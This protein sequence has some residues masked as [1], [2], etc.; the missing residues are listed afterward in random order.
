MKIRGNFTLALLIM[1]GIVIGTL[2][3]NV[4]GQMP[5]LDWLAY[6]I[7]FGMPEPWV[8]NLGVMTV[9]FGVSINFTVASIFGVILGIIVYKKL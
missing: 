8:L 6:G 9:T 4:L 3:G 2:I 5:P 7:N 1:A